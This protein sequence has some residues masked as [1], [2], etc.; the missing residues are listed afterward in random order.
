MEI[1]ALKLNLSHLHAPEDFHSSQHRGNFDSDGIMSQLKSVDKKRQAQ[2]KRFYVGYFTIAA[3]YLAL[4]ILNPDPDLKFNDRINGTLLFIG[5]MVFAILAKKRHF[6]F[7]KIDYDQATT[8]FLSDALN[9]YR[10]WTNDMN[11]VVIG[12]I[13]VNVGSCRIYVLHYPQFDLALFDIL[14]FQ[15]VFIIPLV[16]GLILH[17]RRWHTTS[18]TLF[19][20]LKELMQTESSAT[21]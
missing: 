9:R 12:V 15:A 1:D 21:A 19:T 13:L 8:V 20:E 17:F 6:Q 5:I 7:S 3:L 14:L 11:Y 10:F 16:L 4:F 18:R 2:L